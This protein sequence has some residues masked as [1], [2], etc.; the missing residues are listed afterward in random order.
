AATDAASHPRLPVLALAAAVALAAGWRRSHPILLALAGLAVFLAGAARV[1]VGLVDRAWPTQARRDLEA[2]ARAMERR[3]EALVSSVV[4]SV[5]RVAALPDD[6][7]ALSG[8][9]AAL[10]RL[11]ASL[12]SMR[13][14]GDAPAVA[15]HALP[16]SM[17]A[18]SGRIPDLA[19]VRG[20]LGA[21]R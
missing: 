19:A 2:R 7:A 8:D 9:H 16:L 14:R 4:R 3:K 21:R 11:F 15:V 1:H 17:I 12:E 5:D 20:L 6:R 18:W 13:S 10:I